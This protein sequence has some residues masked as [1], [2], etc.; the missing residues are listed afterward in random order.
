MRVVVYP[1][2][3]VPLPVPQLNRL[4]YI[5]PFRDATVGFDPF[6]VPPRPRLD[7][8]LALYASQG[9]RTC[10]GF[11]ALALRVACCVIRNRVA[12]DE[13]ARPSR[14]CIRKS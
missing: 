7:N 14:S 4:A 12:S 1:G 3:L 9:L 10:V 13:S 11:L 8:G 6:N 2:Q 5:P